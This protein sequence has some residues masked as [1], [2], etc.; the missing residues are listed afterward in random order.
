M[1]Y[2]WIQWLPRSNFEEKNSSLNLKTLFFSKVFKGINK[3]W[4]ESFLSSI[5]LNLLDSTKD[6]TTIDKIGNRLAD[7]CLPCIKA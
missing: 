1:F 4:T 7:R 3:Y 5:I 6:S 2:L